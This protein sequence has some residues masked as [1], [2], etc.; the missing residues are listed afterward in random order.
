MKRFLISILIFISIVSYSQ[1][2]GWKYDDVL[3]SVKRNSD[4]VRVTEEHVNDFRFISCIYGKGSEV[5]A[6]G[7][8]FDDNNICNKVI[9]AY[10]T[11]KI[12]W[13]IQN[14]N[15]LYVK[16]SEYKWKDYKSN[17]YFELA[18]KD[19]MCYVSMYR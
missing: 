13:I 19:D 17:F 14:N 5:V 6:E 3:A 4:Y 10:N 11:E 1:S 18:T 8:Y 7:Y 2:I 15:D 12:N 16:I 9:L